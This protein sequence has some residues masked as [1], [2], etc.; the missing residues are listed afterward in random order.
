MFYIGLDLHTK[1]ITICIL[2]DN[3][4][5]VERC[6]VRQLDQLQQRLARIPAPFEVAFEASCGYGAFVELL[7]PLARRVVVA[8]PGHLKLIYC[9]RKKN[10]RNDAL[11]LAKLLYVDELPQVHVPS[12]DVRAWRQMI[13]FRSRLIQKRT[14]A[15]NG[16]RALLRTVCVQAPC[17]P[18]LWTRRGLDWLSSLPFAQPLHALQRDMLVEELVSLSR[19]IGRVERELA[20]FSRD[21]PAVWQLRSIPGV[22][23]RT[24]EAVVAFLDRPGRFARSKQ[25]GA[26]FGL[27]PSQDQSGAV[28]RLGHITRE[29][30]ATVRQLLTE[31]SWQAV[32]RS[33]TVRAYFERVH[34]G[35]K[36][37]R[38]I[39]LTATAHY[40]AR[41]MWAMLQNG[42][43][44]REQ[45]QA[46]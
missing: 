36:E 45:C 11:R 15:K 12:A 24:A 1:H 26:Y 8:H 9:S 35:D 5:I 13:L 46:V 22:G 37:R 43:L 18:G 21:N 16:L 34:R 39:A 40:L 10:D 32:R 23:L 20:R 41:V 38:K 42:T 3:G 14:R 4:K 29:G 44:W 19:Q 17:R 31:A 27:V 25:V 6:Q 28:N 7:T 33:P 30:P 2:D